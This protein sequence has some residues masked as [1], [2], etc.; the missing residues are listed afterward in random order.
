LIL[1]SW[2][3]GRSEWDIL[4]NRG[5]EMQSVIFKLSDL[6]TFLEQNHGLLQIL[7]CVAGTAIG[8]VLV[9]LPMLVRKSRY[10]YQLNAMKL[11][12]VLLVA[13][14]FVPYCFPLG[15]LN[16]DGAVHQA[17]IWFLADAIRQG[18][19]P[20]W[21]FF[22]FGGGL[23]S[24]CYG[25]IYY[26]V[27]AVPVA[28][29]GMSTKWAIALIVATSSALSA[30]AILRSF[31]PRYGYFAAAMS[32]GCYLFS[33][34][35]AAA[36]WFDGTPHRLIIDCI[37]V[38]YILYLQRNFRTAPAFAIGLRLGFACAG[39]AYFHLQFGGLATALLSTFTALVLAFESTG[40]LRRSLVACTTGAVVF[41]PTAGLHY[42]Y[43]FLA[44]PDLIADND[45]QAFLISP[46]ADWLPNLL[47][48][49]IWDW[50][51]TTWDVHYVGAIPILMSLVAVF[52]LFRVDRFS[53][54]S[55]IFAIL[56]Y[57][58]IPFFPRITVFAPVFFISAV[59]GAVKLIS[60]NLPQQSWRHSRWLGCAL[61]FATLLDL[62][63]S[64]FQ[65]PYRPGSGDKPVAEAL[66]AIGP[67]PGRV[68][69]VAPDK[70]YPN[71]SADR[72]KGFPQ[73]NSPSVFG[74]TFQLSSKMLGYEAMVATQAWRDVESSG[75]ISQRIIDHF[76]AL[77]VSDIL[78]YKRNEGITRVRVPKFRPAWRIAGFS[79]DPTAGLFTRLNWDDMRAIG[80]GE[81][82]IPFDTDPMILIDPQRGTVSGIR[83][84]CRDAAGFGLGTDL[85]AS[86]E[87]DRVTDPSYNKG[88]STALFEIYAPRSGLFVLP[89]GYTRD[90]SIE[91]NGQAIPFYRT[92]E[93]MTV[94]QVPSGQSAISITGQ[95]RQTALR[96]TMD[97]VLAI[98]GAIILL[99]FSGPMRQVW[100]VSRLGT[101][102]SATNPG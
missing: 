80:L 63:P 19:L 2:E 47:T 96:R 76:A 9:A 38:L 28:L 12:F 18:T 23:I 74:P 72:F 35:R 66:A 10:S 16:G 32:A 37:C 83:L 44:K 54:L 40:T 26:L 3:R 53:F 75:I 78:V 91:R 24:E 99:P 51:S 49:S 42:L 27:F 56:L 31:S 50:T 52:L 70:Q 97:L 102:L 60:S 43:Y 73:T 85:A 84:D 15:T 64:N 95:P 30:M 41:V 5:L 1:A 55:G 29:A 98:V 90:I 39:T 62:Y 14:S 6:P 22:W 46:P 7:I 69:V 58:A 86:D 13:L 4:D 34:A 21:S 45:N 79:C 17:K 89:F 81:K 68:A 33:P 57:A 88:M 61:A 87:L 101:K 48:A 71:M 92:S 77:D 36:Y 25:P 94:I 65:M 100:H 59:A 67:T 93:W 8:C 20:E 82:E 11:A